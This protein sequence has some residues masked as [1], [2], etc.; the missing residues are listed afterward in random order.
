MQSQPYVPNLYIFV[1]TPWVCT[2]PADTVGLAVLALNL[3]LIY[4]CS[5]VATL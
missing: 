3:I 4:R 1:L 2:E 5:P